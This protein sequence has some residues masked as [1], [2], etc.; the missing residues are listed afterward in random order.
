MDLERN[1]IQLE[2]NKEVIE[3]R[4]YPPNSSSKF[5]KEEIQKEVLD[6]PLLQS[7]KKVLSFYELLLLLEIRTY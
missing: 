5:Q 2:G 3:E 7:S 1:I 6:M 4:G